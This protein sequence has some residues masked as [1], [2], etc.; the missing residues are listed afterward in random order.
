M[1][2]TC[3]SH[4]QALPL[5]EHVSTG[6]SRLSVPAGGQ[7][8]LSRFSMKHEFCRSKGADPQCRIACSNLHVSLHNV[9]TRHLVLIHDARI[10]VL[11]VRQ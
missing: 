9:N 6:T 1:R 4:A 5:A 11:D 7:R 8:E 2:H 3:I 10:S